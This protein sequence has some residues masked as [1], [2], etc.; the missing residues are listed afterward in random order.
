MTKNQQEEKRSLAQKD[1]SRGATLHNR[2]LLLF[3]CLLVAGTAGYFTYRGLLVGYISAHVGALGV[4]G[5]AGVAT[6]AIAGKKGYNYWRVFSLGFVAP[7]LLGLLAVFAF[8]FLRGAVY[9]GGS[10]S[11]AV[12]LIV[13]LCYSL[14]RKKP[15][16]HNSATTGHRE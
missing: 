14:A 13:L 6:G 8:Y 12:A 2:I 7:I 10:V 9:C 15:R 5:L 16:D 4:M 1:R 3:L 11:L